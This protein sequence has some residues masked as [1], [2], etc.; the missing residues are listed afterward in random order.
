MTNKVVRKTMDF[1]HG[2]KVTVERPYTLQDA[3]DEFKREVEAKGGKVTQ[4]QDELAVSGI[5]AADAM[6][7]TQ[8]LSE[9][10][11]AATGS[12]T[13][14]FAAGGAVDYS[15]L[16]ERVMAH[17]ASEA[18]YPFGFPSFPYIAKAAD[19]IRQST[20][21]AK[22][23][24]K[25]VKDVAPK[26]MSTWEFNSSY[27][28]RMHGQTVHLVGQHHRSKLDQEVLGWKREG[29]M[30]LLVAE[31]D[32]PVDL[33]AVMVLVW[34]DQT[35]NWHHAGYVRA[36]EAAAL[37]GKWTGDFKNVMVARITRI[38]SNP[39]GHRGGRNIQ[40]TATGEVRTYPGYKL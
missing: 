12:T 4:V 36:T 8:T 6:K 22:P 3:L 2:I 7:A 39:D 25:K 1:G 17:L 18:I 16:E 33:N 10:I 9:N 27:L 31:P 34:N 21:R 19:V 14:V 29:N 13:K 38:P 24:P 37:R 32:N 15:G 5:S 23:A 11:G 20:A 40:L 28:Q 26:A 35:K 30:A